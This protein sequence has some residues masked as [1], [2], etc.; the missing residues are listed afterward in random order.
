MDMDAIK[1]ARVHAYY[2][3]WQ[4]AEHHYG[5]AFEPEEIKAWTSVV[6]KMKREYEKAV[7]K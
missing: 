3:L 4:T 7:R 5:E 1:K 6:E 2:I